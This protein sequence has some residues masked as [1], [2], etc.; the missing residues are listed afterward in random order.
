LDPT[1]Q[2]SSQVYNA[3]IC[4]SHGAGIAALAGGDCDGDTVSS[5]FDAR[6][7]AF[8]QETAEAVAQFN[9]QSN[10][11]SPPTPRPHPTSGHFLRFYLELVQD[12]LGWCGLP[13][14]D[15]AN[16]RRGAT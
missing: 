6:L 8:L 10:S 7:V 3:I 4:T 11:C 1:S 16:N 15:K 2:V 12:C 14:K 5:S 9:V 13:F